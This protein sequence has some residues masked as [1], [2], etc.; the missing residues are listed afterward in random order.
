[1]TNS[2]S[3]ECKDLGPTITNFNPGRTSSVSPS[4]KH[5]AYHSQSEIHFEHFP[6]TY[7]NGN[8][9]KGSPVNSYTP[10]NANLSSECRFFC[11]PPTDH[12][13]MPYIASQ[14]RMT[15][16]IL[17]G[18]FNTQ[19]FQIRQPKD[20]PSIIPIRYS[21]TNFMNTLPQKISK[22][23]VKTAPYSSFEKTPISSQLEHPI[24]Q[25]LP[26]FIFKSFDQPPGQTHER[27]D[28]E[29]Q[30]S[31]L[32]TIENFPISDFVRPSIE[33]SILPEVKKYCEEL[34]PDLRQIASR[35]Y[36]GAILK[37]LKQFDHRV[38]L[39]EL[40]NLLYNTG[41]FV[42]TMVNM[43]VCTSP[44]LNA[45]KI[46]HLVL[47]TLRCPQ[48]TLDILPYGSIQKLRVSAAKHQEI[49]RTFLAI[50]ILL[51][52]V[53]RVEYPFVDQYA[54]QRATLYKFYYII[55]QQLIQNYPR[56]SRNEALP[57]NIILGSVI[58]GK[59]VNLVYPKL[60]LKRLG[61][62]GNSKAHYIGIIL[63]YS[64]LDSE[65]RR[66]LDFDLQKLKDYFDSKIRKDADVRSHR[67]PY[68]CEKK[69]FYDI[70]LLHLFQRIY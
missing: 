27:E 59:L 36:F 34:E 42:E 50:K 62:R 37:I 58:I 54:V 24:H 38:S 18:N 43:E 15:N 5:H 3:I 11:K 53:Q 30:D 68:P 46:L 51:D 48:F 57:K 69:G 16:D 65:T 28:K 22:A 64:M 9:E 44:K 63:N 10:L 60:A 67:Q 45:V 61:K 20:L 1:M 23:R 4:Q 52:A 66:L 31:G 2:S 33:Y 55:C 39:D 49:L 14:A 7:L 13:G 56:N 21:T 17:G 25:F 70:S 26:K 35:S 19:T 47:V 41:Q 32:Q 8:N 6:S 29:Y 40:Y 12:S